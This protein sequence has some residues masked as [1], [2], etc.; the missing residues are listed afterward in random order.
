MRNSYIAGFDSGYSLDYMKWI[1]T[2]RGI[3][4]VFINVGDNKSLQNVDTKNGGIDYNDD[5]G[6]LLRKRG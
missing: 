1:Y 4:S 5:I 2:G 3:E 6:I